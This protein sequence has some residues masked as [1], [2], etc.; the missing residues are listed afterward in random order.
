VGAAWTDLGGG[1]GQGKPGRLRYTTC[2]GRG[3]ATTTSNSA[4][5]GTFGSKGS[6]LQRLPSAVGLGAKDANWTGIAPKILFYTEVTKVTKVILVRPQRSRHAY[7]VVRACHLT[8]GKR[9]LPKL[10]S[11][12]FPP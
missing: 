7:W 4:F 6:R 2:S 9:R 11:L 3:R 8:F 1:F 5:F 12:G 10:G